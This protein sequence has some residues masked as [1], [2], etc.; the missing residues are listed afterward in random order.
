M[1]VVL[2]LD[3]GLLAGIPQVIG[4]KINNETYGIGKSEGDISCSRL[5]K[6]VGRGVTQI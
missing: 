3:G 6:N 5:Q 4:A 1:V 2:L